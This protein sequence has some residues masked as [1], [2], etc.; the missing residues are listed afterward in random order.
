MRENLLIGERKSIDIKNEW[1]LSRVYDLFPILKQRQNQKGTT[2]SGG[3]QQML[4]IARA[5]MQNPKLLLFDEVTAGLAPLVVQSILDVL[6]RIKKVA[7]ISILVAEQNQNF[8]FTLS[9]RC[10]VLERG[11]VVYSGNT[12][13]IS[14]D[15][16][17]KYLTA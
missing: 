9:D 2:L 11:T 17:K 13:E 1:T 4:I 16:I 8:A 3:E 6:L 7:D 15:E 5:L 12:K 14:M 10:Y